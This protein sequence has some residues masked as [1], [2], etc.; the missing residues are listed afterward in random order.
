MGQWLS[1]VLPIV[2]VRIVADLA[3]EILLHVK[4]VGMLVRLGG[5]RVVGLTGGLSGHCTEGCSVHSQ[6]D[7]AQIIAQC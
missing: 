1:A 7:W 6:T 3:M 5:A 4:V 2:V